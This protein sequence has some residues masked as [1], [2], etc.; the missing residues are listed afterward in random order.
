MHV[1]SAHPVMLGFWEMLFARFCCLLRITAFSFRRWVSDAFARLP[2]VGLG[3][4]EKFGSLMNVVLGVA[5]EGGSHSCCARK[6]G[7][8][9]ASS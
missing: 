4:L 3:F 1:S 2:V 8:S 6:G 5:D 7:V 9:T